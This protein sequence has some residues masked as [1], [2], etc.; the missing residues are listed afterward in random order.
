MPVRARV[1]VALAAI[2]AAGLA[3]RGDD[4]K[5]G[6]KTDPA[7]ASVASIVGL[8]AI[9]AGVRVVVGVDVAKLARSALVQR[10]VDQ[11]FARDPELEKRIDALLTAC[12][13]DPVEQLDS[14]V[15]G[16]G[17]GDQVVLVASGQFR[18]ADIAICVDKT[19]TA[20]GGRLT[21]QSVAG[22]T[23]YKADGGK[24]WPAVWFAF[25]APNTLVLS[26][27][28]KLLGEA[29]G[30]GKKVATD[31][32][33][34]PLIARAHPAEAA[35]WGAGSVSPAVGEGLVTA[36]SGKVR[37]PRAMFGHVR[38]D[39]G[40]AAELGA[41]M[42][43]ADDA[44]LLESEAKPQLELLSLAAQKYG[45]G[46]LVHKLA[47]SAES[48][49]VLVRIALTEDELRELVSRIDTEEAP[50]QNPA[51]DAGPEGAGNDGKRDA[52]PGSQTPLRE[53]GQAD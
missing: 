41:V 53:Q 8:D 7:R 20:D 17:E 27:S 4:K 34:A 29:L 14:F 11:M 24:S 36:S 38:F 51:F 9:P 28:D 2:A 39:A 43:S 37:P 16:M 32:N 33:L 15:I 46:R 45:L 50:L 19:L 18:E 40:L 23:A 35:M 52:A 21:T 22:R 48:D 30:K 10:A 47:I 31:D 49:T 12:K 3:C 26:S 25:G 42:A 6:T 44:K 5:P 13:L 1:L